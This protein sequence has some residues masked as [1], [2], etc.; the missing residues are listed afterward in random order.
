MFLPFFNSSLNYIL[1]LVKCFI[2]GAQLGGR[3][4]SPLLFFEDRKKCPDF[5]KKGPNCV[6][7]WVESSIPNAV[8]R[9]SRRKSSKLFANWAFFVCVFDGKFIEAP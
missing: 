7:P 2:T 5:G 6:H 4:R 8:L 9:V 3:G 1:A